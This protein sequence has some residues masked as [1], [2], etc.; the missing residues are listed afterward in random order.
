MLSPARTIIAT[1]MRRSLSPSL[2]ARSAAI[3]VIA[4][5]GGTV[6][7][8]IGFL[9]VGVLFGGIST[10]PTA[11]LGQAALVN[12]VLYGASGVILL[13]GVLASALVHARAHSGAPRLVGPAVLATLRVLPRVIVVLLALSIVFVATLF[14]WLPISVLAIAVAAVLFV[15]HRRSPVEAGV[16]RTRTTPGVR[17]ALFAAIPLAVAVAVGALLL[18]VLPAAVAEPRSIRE[19]VARAATIVAAHKRRLAAL[20]ITTFAVAALLSW[21]GASLSAAVDSATTASTDP[22]AAAALG[23]LAVSAAVVL[24]MGT[25]GAILAIAA[26]PTLTGTPTRKPRAPFEVSRVFRVKS[27]LARRLAMVTVLAVVGTLIPVGAQ[28]A[29]LASMAPGDLI[30]P[31]LMLGRDNAAGSVMFTAYVAVEGADPAGTVQF[32]DGPTAIGAPLALQNTGDPTG[33][34]AFFEPGFDPGTHLVTFQYTPASPLVAPATSDV[35]DVSYV[36]ASE[37]MLATTP[38]SG[39]GG[40]GRVEAAVVPGSYETTKLVPTGVVTFNDGQSVIEVPLVGGTAA[41]DIPM[42]VDPLMVVSYSGSDLFEPSQ[43]SIRLD[44]TPP[45]LVATTTTGTVFNPP[46]RVGAQLY[47]SV[48]VTAED[49]SDVRR[50]SIEVYAGSELLTSSTMQS[51][52]QDGIAIPTA[53]LHV[54]TVDLRF[55]YVPGPGYATSESVTTV[56]LV[57]AATSAA[58]VSEPAGTITWGDPHRV[59]VAVTSD[60]D[61]PRTLEVRDTTGGRDTVVASVPFTVA[62]GVASVPVDI[63]RQLLAFRHTLRATVL[64]TPDSDAATSGEAAVDVT[65]APTTT[66]ISTIG[67]NVGEPLTV[68]ARVTSAAGGTLPGNVTFFLDGAQRSVALDATGAATASFVP[69]ELRTVRLSASYTDI[70]SGYAPSSATVDVTVRPIDAPAP[71][72]RWYPINGSKLS[73]DNTRLE[74]TYTAAEGRTTP[75]GQVEILDAKNTVVATGN[76]VDGV[77]DVAVPIVGNQREFRARYAGFSPYAARTDTLPAPAVQNYTPTVTVTAPASVALGVPFSTTVRVTDVPATLIES[78]ILYST[79]AEGVRT[80][81]GA[82][83]MA[84]G[85]GVLEHTAMTSGTV[86][87]SALVEYTAAS[88]LSSTVSDGAPVVV[89]PVP[90]PRLT[91]STPMAPEQLRGGE[92]V[93]LV[94]TAGILGD[95]TY[96]VPAGTSVAVV[97]STGTVL[98]STVLAHSQAGLTGSLRVE[99]L[100]GGLQELRTLVVY[101]PLEQS[102]LGAPLSLHLTTPPTG[103]QVRTA[104]AE[105]GQW[106]PVQVT[107]YP[108]APIVDR[109]RSVPVTLIFDDLRVNIL[110]YPSADGRSY[111]GEG[112]VFT[113]FAGTRPIEVYTP[114]D[115]LTMAPASTKNAVFVDK[116]TTRITA[117]GVQPGI[118]GFDSYVQFR[119]EQWPRRFNAEPTGIVV[120]DQLSGAT[121]T[122]E[123]DS[124]CRLKGADLRSGTSTL[125][126]TFRGDDNNHGSSIS[127]PFEVAPRPSTRFDVSF[128]PTPGNWIS[129]QDVTV[130]WVTKTTGPEAVGRVDATI[131]TSTCS[132]PA[133]EGSCTIKLPVYS[134]SAPPQ[135][136]AHSVEFVPFDDAPP[137]RVT[138]S[139]TPRGCVVISAPGITV[140]TSDATR[141]LLDGYPG[142]LTGS[143]VRFTPELSRGY[144]LQAWRINGVERIGAAEATL[145]LEVNGALNV[146]ADRRYSPKCVTVSV[147]PERGMEKVLMG[148]V[149]LLTRPNCAHPTNPTPQ[150]EID[151]TKG[152]AQ[153]AEGTLVEMQV[154]PWWWGSVPYE[155]RRMIGTAQ[156]DPKGGTV[157][158]L[159]GTENIWVTAEFEDSRCTPLVIEPSLGGSVTHAGIRP[160]ESR[161]VKPQSGACTTGD[162]AAGYIPGTQVTLTA[163]ADSGYGVGSFVTKTDKL[164]RVTAKGVATSDT[165]KDLGVNEV[166][167][168]SVGPQ[169][170]RL[171][172]TTPEKGELRYAASFN[173][174]S[175]VGITTRGVVPESAQELSVTGAEPCSDMAPTR[176]TVLAPARNHFTPR[177]TLLTQKTEWFV[178]SGTATVAAPATI[179][180]PYSGRYGDDT[181][182]PT[183]TRLGG[184]AVVA[185]GVSRGSGPT[186]DLE[187]LTGT[188]EITANYYSANCMVPAVAT[189]VGGSYAVTMD[190]D[191]VDCESPRQYNG[192]RWATFT[193]DPAVNAPKLKPYFYNPATSFDYSKF[194]ESKMYQSMDRSSSYSLLYCAELGISTRVKEVNGTYST[195]GVS[196]TAKF[197]QQDGGCGAQRVLPGRAVTTQ[198]SSA[199]QYLYTSTGN[200]RPQGLSVSVDAVGNVTGKT[201]LEL[202]RICF[203]VNPSEYVWLI[204]PPNCPGG[205]G[206]QYTKGTVVEVEVRPDGERFDGWEQIDQEYGASAW[207]VADRDRN[208][209]ADIHEYR[210][211]E[212]AANWLSNTAQRVVGGLMTI[213]TGIVLGALSLL[214]TVSLAMQGLSALLNVIGVK[215]AFVDGIN[216]ASRVITAQVDLISLA[217]TC[218][219]SWA[220]AAPVTELPS[221]GNEFLDNASSTGIDEI[222]GAIEGGLSTALKNK[223]LTSA[224]SGAGQLGNALTAVNTFAGNTAGYSRPAVE[225]WNR[226]SS[227]MG[228][229]LATGATDYGNAITGD[230]FK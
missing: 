212:T 49:Y 222:T 14:L 103:I 73:P 192:G 208:P 207:V 1:R 117:A 81:I 70:D 143:R 61:G 33:W 50:G 51:V 108:S 121:C 30:V 164:Y 29:P 92:P 2:L 77:V 60:L 154:R 160:N 203:S 127:V 177:E 110:A 148:T 98:G 87:L 225:G 125:T 42:V 220:G 157:S 187:R 5:L 202:Q 102:V 142:V 141:C 229:C 74:L 45:T 175:C 11:V 178:K 112:Q 6:V 223:G 21:A 59:V 57:P 25:C 7:A 195:M 96:G 62:G 189:P 167:T 46:H 99:G 82:V 159:V 8:A 84:G 10:D 173:L 17:R 163:K 210:W 218:T 26:P 72:V 179:S 214:S 12:V 47:G 24:L 28:A 144:V 215:G 170:S 78:V 181:F 91:L 38:A 139:T 131:G 152:A 106:T 79:D 128:S 123:K 137:V 198:I 146:L 136:L 55:V 132:G 111:Y 37:I 118:A 113:Q 75:A 180:R 95:F 39:V 217:A 145:E 122:I 171:T 27:V 52:A 105:L 204:T 130:S 147:G 135:P 191:Y 94:V 206:R 153:Y 68:T 190:D 149:I 120:R 3:G 193:A 174:F 209:T 138:G 162:G 36:A 133:I 183:W 71:I 158:T 65:R 44:G 31:S 228:D 80:E 169:S 48:Q 230:K 213:A 116:L 34:S 119:L 19:L 76:I 166:G 184:S 85:V 224:A 58:L 43:A 168:R 196:E 109:S 107:I 126:A 176:T 216:F 90:I 165:V 150:D 97:D 227:D 40:P 54:G 13:F 101:G 100:L 185:Q 151:F 200:N 56:T 20:T 219:N 129:G 221:T 15:R 115:R 161:Y 156:V 188:A 199:A 205:N 35:A 104:P 114:G 93:D 89:R 194:Q 155:V 182:Y 9:A 140:D 172:L 197:L 67:G 201:V 124:G 66:T 4:L 23:T 41:L 88:D 134:P 86:N 83:A 32:F 22:L 69:Q 211:Y 18:A 226:F 16:T 53:S 64:A 186:I 63:T